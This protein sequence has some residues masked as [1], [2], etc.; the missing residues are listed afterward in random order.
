[1]NKPNQ[2][3]HFLIN[4][5][6]IAIG[7]VSDGCGSGA[8]SQF[9]S[10]TICRVAEGLLRKSIPD[11]LKGERA[12]LPGLFNWL[13]KHIQY[14][15]MEA[16]NLMNLRDP[17]E[18]GQFMLATML[19]FVL[20][21]KD[22]I[23]FHCGDG[24]YRMEAN[25][26]HDCSIQFEGNAP[27]YLA[28]SLFPRQLPQYEDL[29]IKYSVHS[30]ADLRNLIVST[31]GIEEVPYTQLAELTTK[32]LYVKNPSALQRFLQKR[33]K[34]EIQIDFDNRDMKKIPA[35]LKDDTTTIL[36]RRI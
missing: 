19:G 25:V 17:A 10:I 29:D 28:Y 16:I 33:A 12:I 5:E 13:T 6:D 27:P 36:V 32:D 21:E 22:L 18:A 20:T 35:L 8:H 14:G 3:F 30:A 1:L 23:I 4:E 31:D 26:I 34:E 24:Y 2:D 9:G 11:F 7:M 15:L